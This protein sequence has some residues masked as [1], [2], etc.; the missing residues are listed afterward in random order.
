[1]KRIPAYLAAAVVALFWA[2]GGQAA[3]TP[4]E[5]I[6]GERPYLRVPTSGS[7]PNSYFKISAHRP[8]SE[9]DFSGNKPKSFLTISGE[10]NHSDS[11]S[12][13]G[14]LP[15][16]YTKISTHLAERPAT[17]DL[18]QYGLDRQAKVSGRLPHSYFKTAS[19]YPT[20]KAN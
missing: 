9:F 10:F 11:R 2:A 15:N 17:D 18:A 1:M 5:A 19:Q 8:L 13:S 6:S 7:R 20:P 3:N 12:I 14:S 4:D 16:S